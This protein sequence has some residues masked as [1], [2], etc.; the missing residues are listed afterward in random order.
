MTKSDISFF[1]A[2][3]TKL[4]TADNQK[5]TYMDLI[6]GDQRNSEIFF[7]KFYLIHNR[8]PNEKVE[9]CL[10]VELG[11]GAKIDPRMQ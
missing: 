6:G 3:P 8:W 10:K 9:F 11:E 4:K 2:K 7:E 1:L 5:V